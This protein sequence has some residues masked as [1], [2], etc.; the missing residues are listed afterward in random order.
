MGR[1]LAG[2]VVKERCA[3]GRLGEAGLGGSA[4]GEVEEAK[5]FEKV[6]GRCWAC[7][8]GWRLWRQ[9]LTVDGPLTVGLAGDVGPGFVTVGMAV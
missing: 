3:G 1:S 9:R 4:D 6:G 7:W 2:L 5:A 8:F